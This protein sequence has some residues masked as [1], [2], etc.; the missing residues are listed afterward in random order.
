MK[1]HKKLLWLQRER[2]HANIHLQYSTGASCLLIRFLPSSSNGWHSCKNSLM[3]FTERL[4]HINT[5]ILHFHTCRVIRAWAAG[6]ALIF[7]HTPWTWWHVGSVKSPTLQNPPVA[8]CSFG[9]MFLITTFEA[10]LPTKKSQETC[11]DLIFGNIFTKQSAVL[12]NFDDQSQPGRPGE[13]VGI[14]HFCKER[15][16]LSD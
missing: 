7:L 1:L 5:H 10:H 2:K 9:F 14:V 6:R 8:Y 4:M 16:I 15:R 3:S 12:S 11:S 13:D